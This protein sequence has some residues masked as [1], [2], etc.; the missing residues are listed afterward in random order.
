MADPVH[1]DASWAI[2]QLGRTLDIFAENLAVALDTNK[3]EQPSLR[4]RFAMAALTGIS[5]STASGHRLI[6][7]AMADVCAINAYALADAMLV[8]RAPKPEATEGA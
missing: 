8:A 6:T 7:E 2:D 1:L 3:G 4:D 5:G